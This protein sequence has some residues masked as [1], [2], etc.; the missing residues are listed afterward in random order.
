MRVTKHILLF[1]VVLCFVYACSS[2]ETV[3]VVDQLGNPIEGASVQALAA[4]MTGDASLTDSHGEATVPFDSD[5][6]QTAWV[7]VTK[8][9]YRP[10]WV[11]APA[12]WPLRVTLR[13]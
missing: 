6:P 7:V 10:V 9:G 11:D 5:A 8:A 1:A 13:P 3:K 4:A 12:K 2:G